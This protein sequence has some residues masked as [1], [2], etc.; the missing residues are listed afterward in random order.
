MNAAL[1]AGAGVVANRRIDLIWYG[2]A[3]NDFSDV[4]HRDAAV[5]LLNQPL[6]GR[7]LDARE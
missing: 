2:S 3:V 4:C 6:G 7:G 5:E 1:G